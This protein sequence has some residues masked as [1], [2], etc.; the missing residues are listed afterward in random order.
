MLK[1]CDDY[2]QKILKPNY[3]KE[4]LTKLLIN[5]TKKSQYNYANRMESTNMP[6]T[7]K[8][9]FKNKKIKN[10]KVIED[11]QAV[12]KKCLPSFVTY[13]DKKI[14]ERKQNTFAE[15]KR[16]Y[17]SNKFCD[18][19]KK[20]S[21]KKILSPK[22]DVINEMKKEAKYAKTRPIY[23]VKLFKLLKKNILGKY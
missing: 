9:K 15:I 16:A 21:N 22:E 8:L 12:I 7:T 4:F 5:R 11:K 10:N 13:L 3:G 19:L 2:D 23:Q 18:L 17:A 20:F 14:K 1:A 6:T